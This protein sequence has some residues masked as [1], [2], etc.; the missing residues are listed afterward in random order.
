MSRNCTQTTGGPSGGSLEASLVW[1]GIWIILLYGVFMFLGC[2]CSQSQRFRALKQGD[3]KHWDCEYAQP[4]NQV[5]FKYSQSDS[6]P[7]PH[8][9]GRPCANTAN[10]GIGE[11][12]G[13]A[14]KDHWLW[15]NQYLFLE[16]IRGRWCVGV[17]MCACV[18]VCALCVCV[19]VCVWGVYSANCVCVCLLVFFS[20]CF[21]FW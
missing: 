17:C 20:L 8:R 12:V 6:P 3:R 1:V 2:A 18:C 10:G 5:S 7:S 11:R 9:L 13:S 15:I 19:C 21:I 4:R 16:T 14:S